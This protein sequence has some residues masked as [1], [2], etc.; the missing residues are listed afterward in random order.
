MQRAVLAHRNQRPA[1][2]HRDLSRAHSISSVPR[3]RRVANSDRHAAQPLTAAVRS[4][5]KHSRR[6]S[7][8]PKKI[9][10]PPRVGSPHARLPLIVPRV[11]ARALCENPAPV[12]IVGTRG[13]TAG[14]GR[15]LRAGG[16]RVR[17]GASVARTPGSF[18]LRESERASKSAQGRAQ[19]YLA[20]LAG[21]RLRGRAAPAETGQIWRSLR[22]AAQRLRSRHLSHDL[23]SPPSPPVAVSHFISCQ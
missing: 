20:S 21:P 13:L 1:L 10:L 16:T 9:N 5:V 7:S 12:A 3:G 14:A 15:R 11:R 8:A 4:V 22:R 2:G 17:G 18:Q 23:A 19:H 6:H